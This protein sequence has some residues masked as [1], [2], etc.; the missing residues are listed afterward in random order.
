[1]GQEEIKGKLDFFEMNINKKQNI[2]VHEIHLKSIKGN[3]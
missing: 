3:L 2:K 1:M